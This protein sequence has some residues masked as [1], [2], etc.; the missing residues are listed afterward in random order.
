MS[1]SVSRMA[2]FF[3]RPRDGMHLHDWNQTSIDASED[4]DMAP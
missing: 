4:E 1:Q 2:S 3:L